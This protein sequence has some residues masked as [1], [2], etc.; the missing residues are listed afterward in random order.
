MEVILSRFYDI[1]SNVIQYEIL[2]YLTSQERISITSTHSLFYDYSFNKTTRSRT[3]LL[4]QIL[5]NVRDRKN[6]F[7]L[8]LLSKEEKKFFMG[9]INECIRLGT[10]LDQVF[11]DDQGVIFT[12]LSVAIT[13]GN[14]Y[15]I[16]KIV[17]SGVSLD[18]LVNGKSYMDLVNDI[19]EPMKYIYVL[20][21]FRKLVNKC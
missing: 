13:H 20:Q 2:P 16:K 14:T 6:N 19:S 12:P 7:P 4:K 18:T 3:C 1:G 5:L 17:K 9:F 15:I 21:S 11:T 8:E 10:S